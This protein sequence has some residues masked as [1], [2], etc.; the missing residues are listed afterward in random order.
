M[1]GFTFE[2]NFGKWIV[3]HYLNLKFYTQI[4]ILYLV[5]V[6]KYFHY[7]M[8]GLQY[9]V[10]NYQNTQ[11]TMLFYKIIQCNN[12]N[13]K[14][15]KHMFLNLSKKVIKIIIMQIIVKLKQNFIFFLI[16]KGSDL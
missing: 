5:V 1:F 6:H 15:Q 14:K 8:V 13:N 16:N 10:Q 4:F 9:A 3:K 2:N 7:N 11:Y 12:I